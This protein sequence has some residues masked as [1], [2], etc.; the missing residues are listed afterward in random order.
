MGSWEWVREE[1]VRGGALIG[2]DDIARVEKSWVAA[3]SLVANSPSN[4]DPRK[5]HPM[6][7]VLMRFRPATDKYARLGAPTSAPADRP[8]SPSTCCSWNDVTR[9]IMSWSVAVT[10]QP[11]TSNRR[12]LPKF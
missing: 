5:T 4:T 6:R 1:M 12:N 8:D 9:R 3:G 7:K 10:L 2:S 11:E